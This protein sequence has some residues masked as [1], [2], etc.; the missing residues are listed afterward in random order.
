MRNVM[1]SQNITHYPMVLELIRKSEQLFHNI[2][3][4]DSVMPLQDDE[5]LFIDA[6]RDM[7][8]Q[9]SRMQAE[10]STSV[11]A[12]TTN[13]TNTASSHHG[14]DDSTSSTSDSVAKLAQLAQLAASH[15]LSPETPTYN[16]PILPPPPAISLSHAAIAALAVAPVIPPATFY[17]NISHYNDLLNNN[18]YNNLTNSNTNNSSNSSSDNKSDKIS[19]G[20]TS[21]QLS[22][23]LDHATTLA[24]EAAMRLNCHNAPPDVPLA[25]SWMH[26]IVNPA[27]AAAAS[28]NSSNAA[29]ATTTT[30][31]TTTTTT[32]DSNSDSKSSV[33]DN[34]STHNH[35]TDKGEN[36]TTSLRRPL[37]DLQNNSN[38]NPSN[39]AGAVAAGA[40]GPDSKRSRTT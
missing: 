34:N 15:P 28:A 25:L 37:S 38:H 32:N 11:A 24:V 7:N 16:K 1:N 8:Y 36:A 27:V 39:N 5:R 21:A 35:N 3:T 12:G 29:A 31:I 18:S 23:R 22:D 13:A 10:E 4:M 26:R 6:I 19:N 14:N 17:T 20:T 9:A 40:D 2:Q 33:V 30:T